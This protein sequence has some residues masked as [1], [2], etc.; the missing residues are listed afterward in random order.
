[1]EPAPVVKHTITN[2]A[3]LTEEDHIQ[4]QLKPQISLCFVQQCLWENKKLFVVVFFGDD[5]DLFQLNQAL[6]LRA[7]KQSKKNFSTNC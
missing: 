7:E 3:S 6:T 5:S 2:A 4:P 1:M